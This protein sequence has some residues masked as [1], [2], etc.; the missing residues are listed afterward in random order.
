[1]ITPPKLSSRL[2]CFGGI[3]SLAAIIHLFAVF[4]LVNYLHVQALGANIIAFLL[5]F[6]VSYLGHKYLT[7]SQLNDEKTLS[8]PHFFLVA[9][10]A[11]I[12]NEFLYFILLRFTSLNYLFAL[13]I[14]L[15]CV[16]VYNFSLSKLWAC[17]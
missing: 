1:M 13:F 12:M 15:A 7:F 6:N 10:S 8:L 14:V 3:G 4:N 17:R 9:T 2:I 11:G 5:A 16:S